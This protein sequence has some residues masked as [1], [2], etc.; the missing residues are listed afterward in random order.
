MVPY[1]CMWRT[2]G[3]VKAEG[4]PQIPYGLSNWPD[5]DAR[6]RPIAGLADA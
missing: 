3:I 1:S 6:R 5:G 4:G 2:M